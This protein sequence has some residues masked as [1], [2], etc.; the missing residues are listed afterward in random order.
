MIGGHIA[1][2]TLLAA[3]TAASA[4]AAA[5]ALAAPADAAF[6]AT[7]LNLSATGE[8]SAAPD[9]ASLSLGVS[10]LAPTAAQALNDNSRKMAQVIAALR[11]QG[12]PERD[13][14]TSSLSVEPQYVFTQGQPQRL[15]GYQARNQVT[16]GVQDMAKI[17]PLLDAAVAAGANEVSGLSFG[18]KDPQQAEDQARLDAVKALK[19]KAD[20]YA[21]ATGYRVAR[22]VSLSEGGGFAPQPYALNEAVMVT[23]SRKTPTP[24]AAGDL[25]IRVQVSAVYELAK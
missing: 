4:L 7:T 1:M 2:K 18:I 21:Q 5:P 6:A 22:L 13:I 17:G 14:R 3:L 25:V 23:A 12:A 15:T 19:A 9:R 16:V 11:A 8:T 10:A 20:L 24:V